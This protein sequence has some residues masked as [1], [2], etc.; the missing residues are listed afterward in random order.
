MEIPKPL[1]DLILAHA[2]LIPDA[3]SAFEDGDF[4][5]S[6]KL[7]NIALDEDR[8]NWQVRLQL[9]RAY[10]K[11]G[12]IYTAALHFRY[13]QQRCTNPDVLAECTEELSA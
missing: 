9:A 12:D 6:V 2:N 5:T 1:E 13:L 8:N 10:Q 4:A 11:M 3:L 7:F